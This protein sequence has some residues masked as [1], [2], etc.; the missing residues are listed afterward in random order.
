MIFDAI[1]IVLFLGDLKKVGSCLDRYWQMKKIMAPGCE[2]QIIT[3]LMEALRPFA[4]G[5]CMAGAGGGGFMYV[6]AKDANQ[7]GLIKQLIPTIKV[8]LK[9][10]RMFLI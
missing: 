8:N 5:I 1:I 10:T 9:K 7:K 2:T 3:T 4:L 6:L